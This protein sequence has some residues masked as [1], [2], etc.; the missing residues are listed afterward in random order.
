[1]CRRHLGKNLFSEFWI[2]DC[3]PV[4][5]MVQEENSEIEEKIEEIH[6]LRKYEGEV[7]PL[8]V[9]FRSQTKAQDIL[10]KLY[11]L[12]TDK[13]FIFYYYKWKIGTYKNKSKKRQFKE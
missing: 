7:R 1:M 11:R 9:K 8:K 4:F 13:D 2:N 10:S 3:E 12:A 5:H 6:M